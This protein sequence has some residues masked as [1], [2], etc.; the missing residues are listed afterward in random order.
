[1]ELFFKSD[2]LKQA[3]VYKDLDEARANLTL[4]N[5][6]F[7]IS[8]DDT[9]MIFSDKKSDNKIVTVEFYK[10]IFTL[11][12]NVLDDSSG[13]LREIT[14]DTYNLVLLGAREWKDEKGMIENLISL[15][16]VYFNEELK[17]GTN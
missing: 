2:R 1:M 14:F 7:A 15:D 10:H 9:F 17:N 3:F 13:S 5:D 6:G 8:I 16:T 12:V 11:C 4:L